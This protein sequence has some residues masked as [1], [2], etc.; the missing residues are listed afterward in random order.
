[1]KKAKKK[2]KFKKV[3]RAVRDGDLGASRRGER[4][5]KHRFD[6]VFAWMAMDLALDLGEAV[7]D[8]RR[9]AD[10]FD[11]QVD[12]N[13]FRTTVSKH[14]L[15]RAGIYFEV[16]VFFA[17]SIHDGGQPAFFAHL[18]ETAGTCTVAD[19]GFEIRFLGHDTR[20]CC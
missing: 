10:A 2:F 12:E 19:S 13:V 14:I 6:R 1:M 9:G 11:I 20:A 8:E 16:L 17:Q 15:E 4:N 7:D 3:A 18:V 5:E